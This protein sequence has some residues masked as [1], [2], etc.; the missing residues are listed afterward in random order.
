MGSIDINKCSADIQKCQ[1]P[2]HHGIRYSM[3]EIFSVD[4]QCKLHKTFLNCLKKIES[5][6]S[7]M[8]DINK[9]LPEKVCSKG[10]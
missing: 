1:L 10:K 9:E 5:C 6:P 3:R 7:P 2:L 8:L 4:K